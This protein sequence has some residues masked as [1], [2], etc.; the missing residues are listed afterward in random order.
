MNKIFIV[1]AD[2]SKHGI[3]GM[4]T[5][6]IAMVD[7]FRRIP[8][9]SISVIGLKSNRNSFYNDLFKKWN[10]DLHRIIDS[11]NRKLT[12]KLFLETITD[13]SIVFFNSPHW[14]S[15]LK[16]IKKQK[17]NCRLIIRS[18]GND[19]GMPWRL[20]GAKNTFVER[21]Y[22][23][24]LGLSNGEYIKKKKIK[25]INS[26]VDT[27]ITN[28]KYSTEEA[29][30]LDINQ[31][32]L[33]Q[34]TGGVDCKAIERKIH[35]DKTEL[36]VLNIGR[37]RN[38]KGLEYSI[39]AFSYAQKHSSLVLRM[40]IIG[41]GT[42]KEEERIKSFVEHLGVEGVTFLEKITYPEILD[43]YERGDIFLHMPIYELYESGS[44]SFYRTETMGRSLLEA[45]EAGLPVIATSVG[46]VRETVKDNKNGFLVAEKDY[47]A[48]GKKLLLLQDASLRNEF[49]LFGRLLAENEYSYE[50][51]FDKYQNLFHLN[52]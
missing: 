42:K 36:V 34:I 48:A 20:G 19:L 40:V 30:K 2:G 7:Y 14:Y 15:I 5:H 37:M 47:V 52:S 12:T 46:G 22:R 23:L 41:E 9:Y 11:K 32:I 43:Y 29:K 26:Y 21:L 50:T 33:F 1:I 44:F 31:D 4:E 6:V 10:I 49:G 13:N 24:S 39:K 35:E 51:I 8:G 3:G 38:F 45:F 17:R 28:S 27:L 25:A 16:K 18:G